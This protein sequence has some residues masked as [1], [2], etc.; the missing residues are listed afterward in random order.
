MGRAKIR[1]NSTEKGAAIVS[2][3]FHT[4]NRV[5]LFVFAIFYE[6]EIFSTFLLQILMKRGDFV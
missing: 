4:I 6:V 1:W 2:L 3:F 5:L